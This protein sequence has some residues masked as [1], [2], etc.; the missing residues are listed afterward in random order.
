V[1]GFT[2]LATIEEE[3]MVIHLQEPQVPVEQTENVS[4]VPYD[5][6]QDEYMVIQADEEEDGYSMYANARWDTHSEK[7]QQV[8]SSLMEETLANAS[9]Q[10]AGN[11]SHSLSI[12]ASTLKQNVYERQQQDF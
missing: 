1:V 9:I 6:Y 11:D 5:E 12:T 3:S 7:V 4:V 2:N 8:Q 10:D